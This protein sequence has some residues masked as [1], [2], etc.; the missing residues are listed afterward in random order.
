MNKQ[1]MQIVYIL[2]PSFL[3]FGSTSW[4]HSETISCHISISLEKIAFHSCLLFIGNCRKQRSVGGRSAA[5]RDAACLKG[6]S[7]E[8][9]RDEE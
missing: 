1:M 3:K 8:E 2:T 9:G 5:A 6:G 4:T 7:G